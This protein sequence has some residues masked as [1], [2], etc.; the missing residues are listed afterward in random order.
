[1][2]QRKHYEKRS[3]PWGSDRPH[4]LRDVRSL[5]F[6][7]A[8][9]PVEIAVFA[10][11]AASAATDY[12]CAQEKKQA[13]DQNSAHENTRGGDRAS[14]KK[15][16]TQKGR[17]LNGRPS[18][19]IRNSAMEWVPSKRAVNLLAGALGGAGGAAAAAANHREDAQSDNESKD[20]ALHLKTP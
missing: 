3:T 2:K 15:Q 14:K 10:A 19:H 18:F 9:W 11:F 17:P 5:P 13:E 20:N 7:C 1:M 4:A 16:L 12:G 8:D 6:L